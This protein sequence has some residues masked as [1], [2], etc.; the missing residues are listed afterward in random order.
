MLNWIQI[1]QMIHNI[2]QPAF[3]QLVANELEHDPNVQ[4]QKNVAFISS[5]QVSLDG[6]QDGQ[7][8]SELTAAKGGQQGYFYS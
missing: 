8:T 2:P 1:K 7:L 6:T 3:E 5:H 4:L